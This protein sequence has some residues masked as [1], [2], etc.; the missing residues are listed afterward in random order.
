M[1]IKRSMFEK[2]N[3]ETVEIGYIKYEINP[4]VDSSFMMNDIHEHLETELRNACDDIP[5]KQLI[6]DLTFI[7][8]L[9]MYII[10]KK[11]DQGIGSQLIKEIIHQYKNKNPIVFV[12]AGASKKIYNEPI[13]EPRII[14]AILDTLSHFF[15]RNNFIDVTE[16]FGQ[17]EYKTG[18]VYNNLTAQKVNITTKEDLI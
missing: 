4:D 1:I 18:Y 8:I 2:I 15:K 12:G 9:D 10:K 16:K 11:R 3:G 14:N 6:K 13:T 7:E 17:Y 5:K